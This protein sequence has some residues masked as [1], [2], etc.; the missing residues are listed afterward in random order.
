MRHLLPLL[1]LAALLLRPAAQDGGLSLSARAGFD[2]LYKEM[3]AV[4][5]FVSVRNDGPPIEGEIRIAVDSM[6]GG[7]VV[8]SA[9]VSL[10][11]GSDKRVALYI[12]VLTFTGDLN[13]QLVSDETVVATADSNP[14][15]M[16]MR[17]H[18]LYGVITS[19]PSGL[20]FLET[21]SGSRT[22]ADVA[23][24]DL[25]DLPD[26]SIA[27][28][29]LDVLVLDDVDTSRLT[30]GQLTALRAWLENGGQLVVTGGPGGP[31]TAAAVAD[32]LPV[33]VGGVESAD[34]L[35]ALS[36]F[37]G[38][39]FN[40]PGPYT[41]TGSSLRAGEL[42]IHQDGL[43]ILAHTP[44]GLGGVTFLALDPKLAPLAGW[45]GHAAV[46][47]SIAALTST[48]GPYANGIQD[49][50][51]ATQAASSIPGL[52]L[53]SVGQLLLFLFVYTLVIGPINFLVLRRLR[54]RELA[55]V[56][57]PVLVLLFS[58]IT[59]FTSFRSRGGAV[60]QNE[61]SVAY[62][63]VEAERVR[64]QSI[65]GLYSPQRGR[66]D[67]SLPYDTTAFP[68]TGQFGS[69]GLVSNLAAIVRAGDLTLREVR[70]DTGEVV[71]FLVDAHRPR[72][73][74]SATARLVDDGRAV[75]VTVRND[76][77]LTL[78]NAVLL[79]GDQQRQ[80]DDLA[81]GAAREAQLPVTVLGPP[82]ATP[83]P[84]PYMP[85]A[86]LVPSPL[87]N[88]PTY[89]LGTPDYFSDPNVYARWQLVQSLYNYSDTSPV[90][91]TDPTKSI[92]LAGWLPDSDQ[93]IDLGDVATTRSAATLVLLEIPVR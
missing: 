42:L 62:G 90:Q 89:I 83:T 13:V 53:P 31:K 29:A 71:A 91:Q 44:L 68:L 28:R 46:W 37:G 40:A 5:V 23:F 18:L 36:A 22:D 77:A 38:V 65:V 16:T 11:T 27:W 88:D 30:A 9:P 48:P 76:G 26:V 61:M 80:L 45:R 56:T 24:L 58:A 10:P 86:V 87:I 35:P 55:W 60:L 17:H 19:D 51:A 7:P 74:L 70:A 66:Y 57:I 39:A 15:I 47:E 78:E 4:P 34:D 8:Y 73:P 41:L 63:S 72:P 54:R 92:I 2:G 79:Y 50:Y 43:P 59:F 64:T 1:W 93:P 32:L 81:P 69:V 75:A 6:S 25:A 20:A 67:L 12:D 3:D 52:R 85:S 14:L 21:V 84:D 49:G 82:G 33:T